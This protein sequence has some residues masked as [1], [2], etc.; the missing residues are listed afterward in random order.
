MYKRQVDLFDGQGNK[1]NYGD[2]TVSLEDL[3]KQ[4]DYEKDTNPVMMELARSYT[5]GVLKE[6]PYQ[7]KANAYLYNKKLFRD[8]GIDKAPSNWTEFLDTCQKLKDSG[9]IPLTTDCL[10]YTSRCV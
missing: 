10:L 2:R 7:F 5:D 9:V 8:A 6:I 1:S 4:F 3:V